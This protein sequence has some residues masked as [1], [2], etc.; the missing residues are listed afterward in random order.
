MMYVLLALSLLLLL[1]DLV[2]LILH[3]H[4]WVVVAI[5]LI[6]LVVVVIVGVLRWDGVTHSLFISHVDSF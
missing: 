4:V 2:N 5:P 3:D 1:G 6:L